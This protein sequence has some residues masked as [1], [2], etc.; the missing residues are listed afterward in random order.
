MHGWLRLVLAAFAVALLSPSA[1]IA[2]AP[3]YLRDIEPIFLKHCNDCH[4]VDISQQ[5]LRLDS[6]VGLK[7]GGNSGAVFVPGKSTESLLIDAIT[8]GKDTAKMPPEDYSDPLPAADVDLIRRWIDAGAV[9]PENAVEKP[10]AV[11]SDH[12]AFQPIANVAPPKVKNSGW[13]QTPIDR[14]LL[15]KLEEAG[16][17]PSGEADRPTQ[18]RRLYLD[19]LGMPPSVEAVDEFVHDPA[20]DAY[21]QLVDRVLASPHY[22]ERWGRH[23]LDQARYADSNGY[24][25]DSARS[26][27]NYRDW[28]IN[29]INCDQPFDQFS[30]EQLAGDMLPAPTREQLIATGFHRNTLVNEEGGT[31]PEQFRVEAVVDRVSTTGSVFMG[32]TVGCARCHDHKYDPISQREFYQLFAVF[33]GADEPSLEL[34][35]EQE[36][37]EEA[38]LD[39]DIATVKKRLADVEA[40]A[41]GRQKDWEKRFRKELEELEKSGTYPASAAVLARWKILLDIPADKRNA[42]QAKELQEEYFKHDLERIPL[43]TQLDGLNARKKQLAAKITT[44]LIMRERP[45]PRPTHVHM[46][47]DFLRP[48]AQ[49]AGATPAVLPPAKPSG[50][51]LSRLEF[52]KWLFEPDH[53]LTSRVTVNRAWQ[54]LFGRGLVATENDFG[55]QGDAPSHP[56]LLDWLSRRFQS[57]GWSMKALH[58]LIVTSAAYRQSSAVRAELAE[59]DPYN[60]LVGRQIRLRLEAEVIRDSALASSGLLIDR[61]GGPGVYPPQP[62]GIYKFTQ[63]VKFW[64]QRTP[65][66]KYRRG[67]YTFFWRSSPYPFLMTFDAP[68]S[69]VTCTRRARS[70]TPLQSLTLANDAAF[71]DLANG[72]AKRVL[73]EASADE[74]A[75]IDYAFRL[76]FSREPSADEQARLRMFVD[77]ERK[78]LADKTPA[79]ELDQAVWAATARVL[80]NLDE[81]VTRE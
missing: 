35:T 56:E 72:L 79:E 49:V 47:G 78:R 81:F 31:D 19:L 30:I 39:A 5:D 76:C 20:S 17:A 46:R 54:T 37:G 29:S 77:S 58:R 61:L 10:K 50:S 70:N 21:E 52:S 51:R 22:G 38:P 40:N 80:M 28:V 59:K 67:I 9:G 44:T 73:K 25:I 7:R 43:I 55:L 69:N 24:T 32:L 12:W 34:P 15:A 27:W 71:V 14:F 65:E 48:G 36:S 41:P 45:E 53:P 8:A 3:D 62:E 6:F 1:V 74:T 66:D 42:A 64:K 13:C 60:T 16:L 57:D 2:E 63:Q 4:G 11:K 26:M 23:W 33:N 75:R 18:I 68:D